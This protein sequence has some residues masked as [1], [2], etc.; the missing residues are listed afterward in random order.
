MP[1]TP[2]QRIAQMLAKGQL[3]DRVATR[4]LSAA[5]GPDQ[6]TSKPLL[7]NLKQSAK[8]CGLSEQTF[9]HLHRA[10]IFPAVPFATSNGES[11]WFRVADLEAEIA[12]RVVRVTTAPT[13]AAA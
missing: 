6:I 4:M 2:Q 10:G 5:A 7:L 8:Y 11:K 12:K 3:D 13:A 1:S 9:R